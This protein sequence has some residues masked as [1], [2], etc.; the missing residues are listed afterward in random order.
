MPTLK[1]KVEKATNLKN[2]DTG[3]LNDVTDCTVKI[4]WEG[5]EV[6]TRVIS[7]NLNPVWNEDFVINVTDTNAVI[8]LLL[9]DADTF[10]P[11]ALFGATFLHLCHLRINVPEKLQLKVFPGNSVL[12]V[13]A[14]ADFSGAVEERKKLEDELKILK[15]KEG[16]G[17]NED[18]NKRQIDDFIKRFDEQQRKLEDDL[19]KKFEDEQKKN[20]DFRKQIEASKPGASSVEI[21]KV[22]SNTR[23]HVIA[24]ANWVKVP[25]VV[26]SFKLLQPAEI[27]VIAHGI[28][29]S[30]SLDHALDVAI[31]VDDK[32]TGIGS[33][34]DGL[35]PGFACT[36]SADTRSWVTLVGLA[37]ARLA[38]GDHVIDLRFRVRG[39]GTSELHGPGITIKI[40]R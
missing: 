3:I 34:G 5:H 21:V 15:E 39:G 14:I 18:N 20:D 40:F 31:F 17:K 10:L 23:G 2:M 13:E 4:L 33:D 6:K 9:F 35:K 25:N 1:L 27:E 19:R 16:Q 30:D 22:I 37:N 38:P 32:D 11:P 29:H 36:H 7:N 12:F 26:H 28:G 24:D 8:Q